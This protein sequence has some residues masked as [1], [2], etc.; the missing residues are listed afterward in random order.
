MESIIRTYP[1]EAGKI[2]RAQ[3]VKAD[4]FDSLCFARPSYD[5]A[6]FRQIVSLYQDHI[7][8]KYGTFF[9]K[10]ILF[11]TDDQQRPLL[12]EY[13]EIY[14][15]LAALTKDLREHV[16]YSH[17]QICFDDT[18]SEKIFH[19]LQEKGQFRSGRKR[20]RISFQEFFRCSA[21]GQFLVLSDGSMGPCFDL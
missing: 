10:I 2:L 18:D 19:A 12:P 17:D 6:S 20:M 13:P 3:I 9:G 14:D 1:L 8:K 5:P 21:G 7:I 16:F 11:S 15:P 4:S